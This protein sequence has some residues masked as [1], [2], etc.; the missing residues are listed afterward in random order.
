[1]RYATCISLALALLISFSGCG[2]V[3]YTPHTRKQQQKAKP[4]IVLIQR[5]IEFREEFNAWPLSKEEFIYKSQKYKDAFN[6]FPYLSVVFRPIDNDRMTFIFTEH[7][8]DVQLARE[9]KQIDLNS[10][11]GEV[12]FYKEKNQFVWKIKMY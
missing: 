10:F 12:R 9:N 2:L 7:K 5:I 3:T 1:M 4:S 6:D 11:G 8:K